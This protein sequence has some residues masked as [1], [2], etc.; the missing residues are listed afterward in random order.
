MAFPPSTR[1]ANSGMP[2]LVPTLHRLRMSYISSIVLAASVAPQEYMSISSWLQV[3]FRQRGRRL[4]KEHP[5]GCSE[6]RIVT[7]QPGSPIVT[8]L[9]LPLNTSD[10]GSSEDIRR[11]LPFTF[12]HAPPWKSGKSHRQLVPLSGHRRVHDAPPPT[13]PRSGPVIQD[14]N[15]VGEV[16]VRSIQARI[17]QGRLFQRRGA[18]DCRY[19]EGVSRP[20][21][22]SY[23]ERGLC[24]R[25]KQ[26]TAQP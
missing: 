4:L 14:G 19:C 15:G 18:Y 9:Y 22:Q 17:R 3:M 6:L 10:V 12:L 1:L 8:P 26:S 16:R 7:C 13:F 24:F 2:A 21:W 5:P 23:R 25:G 11:F 20:R